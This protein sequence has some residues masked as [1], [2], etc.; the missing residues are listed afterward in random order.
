M[1]FTQPNNL[2][3]LSVTDIPIGEAL[4]MTGAQLYPLSEKAIPVTGRGG[5]YGFET[6]R[7]PHFLDNR[8]T[9]AGEGARLTS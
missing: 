8:P 1:R 7:L 4:R 5:P 9:D 3:D 2:P 6:S